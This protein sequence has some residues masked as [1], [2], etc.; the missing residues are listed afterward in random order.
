MTETRFNGGAIPCAFSGNKN[1]RPINI[2]SGIGDV[3]K[4][5]DIQVLTQYNYDDFIEN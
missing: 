4:S 3:Y 2:N 1:F 5:Y